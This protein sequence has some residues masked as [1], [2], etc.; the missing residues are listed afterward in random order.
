[1][2]RTRRISPLGSPLLGAPAESV[3][4]QRVRVQT[5]LTLLLLGTNIAGAAITAV[6]IN[7]VIPGPSVL[8]PEFV[9]VTGVVAPVYVVGAIVLGT[10]VGTRRGLAQLRWI[11][12]DR[13]PSPEERRATMRLPM[14]LTAQQGAFWALG[15]VLFATAFGVLDPRTIPKVAFTIALAGLTV[16]G[17]VFLF[18]EFA[19]R[20][21]AARALE[22][23]ATPRRRLTGTSGRIM[24]AWVL[25]SAVPV[26]GLMLVAVF[27]F[28]R[29]VSPVRFAVTILTIGGLAL[30]LGSLLMFLTA[31]RSIA[32]I[33]SVRAGMARIEGGDLDAEVVVYDGT[34]LG[35][36]QAGFNRMADGL[37]E[38]ERIRDVFGRHVGQDVAR[39]AL[40][41]SPRLGGEERDVAV[42]FID[43]IGSTA[44]AADRPPTEV[45]Q[46]LNRFFEV[47]VEEVHRVGG[48]V[49]KFEGDAA[50]AIFGAPV[51]MDDPPGNALVAARTMAHR[52]RTDVPEC[53]AGIGVAAG[54]A[55]AGNVGAH[56]R[57]EYTVIGDP[58]NEA[59]RLSDLAKT[60][61]GHVVASSRAVE[62]AADHERTRWAPKGEVT[63]RGRSE[64][65]RLAVPSAD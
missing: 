28:V 27:S 29:P 45:V 50:L 18:S 31:R 63:L 40:A 56:E 7:V 15:L 35:E 41:S 38:R 25:G 20:P 13:D 58:V 52:L 4:R 1:M 39:A 42:L 30:V 19:L 5:L 12:E 26:I 57:F 22:A 59:A 53:E 51:A 47:V 14:R 9:V 16:C 62:A 36:L 11:L 60:I 10:I 61:P 23:G 3:Q 2:P 21:I 44:M 33:E 17:F 34:E 54:L 8:R 48:F 64:V 43:I 46:L 24:V 55:V 65:T 49:N 32:P 6:L 37:R